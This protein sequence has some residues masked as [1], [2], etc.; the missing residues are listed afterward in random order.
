MLI[1]CREA[2]FRPLFTCETDG[3]TPGNLKKYPGELI[4]DEEP[5]SRRRDGKS[6]ISNVPA[7]LLNYSP[8]VLLFHENASWCL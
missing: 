2:E 4:L 3:V 5:H 7:C 8:T 1:I 6:S